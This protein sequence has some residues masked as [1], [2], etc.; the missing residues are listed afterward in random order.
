MNISAAGGRYIGSYREIIYKIRSQ[1]YAKTI[2]KRCQN[3]PKTMPKL[4]QNDPKTIQ[5][6][7]HNYPK[8]IPKTV[9]KLSKNY[10][11]TYPK[12][13]PTLSKSYH[14]TDPNNYQKLFQ[15]SQHNI[16]KTIKYMCCCCFCMWLKLLN[17]RNNKMMC[18]SYVFETLTVYTFE[19]NMKWGNRKP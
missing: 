16:P 17:L 5:Q 4:H 15:N 14:K 8:T 9:P 12:T 18:V 6:L 3:Y 19:E 11:N 1:N 10:K 2:P 7:S 13:D